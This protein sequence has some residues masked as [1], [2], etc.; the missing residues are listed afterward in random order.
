MVVS[1]A[2]QEV[3]SANIA[4]IETAGY[5]RQLLRE[6]VFSQA[7][8]LAQMGTSSNPLGATTSRPALGEPSL[9]WAR[10]QVTA[11]DSPYHMAIGSRGF[12]AVQTGEGIRYTRAGDFRLDAGG[13]LADAFGGRLLLSDGQALQLAAGSFKVE[14]NGEV[15]QNGVSLGTIQVV[16]FAD[17]EQLTKDNHGRFI[18]DGLA[19][20]PVAPFVKQHHLELSNVDLAKEIMEMMLVTRVFQS[21]QRIVATYDQLMDRTKD[22]GSVR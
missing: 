12:F 13:N 15:F 9:D 4:N 18:A 10:G 7:M 3:V 16:D 19:Q 6:E 8:L 11:S 2:R 17:L 22:I 5:K 1:K 21:A 14:S 20:E